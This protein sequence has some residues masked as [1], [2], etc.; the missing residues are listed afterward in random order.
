MR[1]VGYVLPVTATT[2]KVF[3]WRMR[4]VE[5]LARESWR[6]LYRAKLEANHWAVL[7]Q[8]RVMLEGMPDD[9]RK[10]EMLYQHDLGISR[11]RQ[12]LTR[13]AKQQ[14]EAEVAAVAAQ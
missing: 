10:R 1:I 5:G 14:I 13:A 9:A 12:I 11:I 4:K 8:D 2:C 3:F 6:F 7:E